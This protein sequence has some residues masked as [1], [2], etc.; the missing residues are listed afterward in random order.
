M[1]DVR[2]TPAL[3]KFLAPLLERVEFS[4]R[5]LAASTCGCG[6]GCSGGGGGGGGGGNAKL[7]RDVLLPEA[8]RRA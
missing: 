2:L 5:D 1:A 3:E 4:A 8:S 6:C 7:A